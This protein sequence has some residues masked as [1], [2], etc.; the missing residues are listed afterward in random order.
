M[1]VLSQALSQKSFNQ[2]ILI[3]ENYPEAAAILRQKMD[4]YDIWMGK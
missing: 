4:L 3:F 2:E 1:F